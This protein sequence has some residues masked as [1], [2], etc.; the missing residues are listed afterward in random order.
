MKKNELVKSVSLTFNKVG[1]QLQKKSPE[2][3]LAAG[4]VGVVVSAAMACK[5]TI[6]ATKVAEQ[7]ND[8]LEHIHVSEETGVTPAGKT[9]SKE[10][11]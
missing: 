2:I 10:D 4:I 6:K 7:A 3:L 8:D 5:A 1:F 9:Y 11:A